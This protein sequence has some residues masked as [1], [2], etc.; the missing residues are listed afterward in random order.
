MDKYDSFKFNRMSPILGL[1]LFTVACDQASKFLVRDSF[2]HARPLSFLGGF[3]RITHI[4]NPG[5]LF[6]L[7]SHLSESVRFWIFTV[8][9]SVVLSVGVVILC[10]R[11]F[12][13]IQSI[14]CLLY[15]SPS[16]RDRQKSRMPSSA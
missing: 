7:G 11:K 2:C 9:M 8:F 4:E 13:N 1:T 12:G 6:G 14:S 5:V 16:P 3:F 10:R 15:T